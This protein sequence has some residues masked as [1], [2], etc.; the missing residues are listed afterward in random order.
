MNWKSARLR[1]LVLVMVGTILNYIARNS[2]GALAPQL[3]LDLQITTEQYSY[4]VGAFQLAYTVMQPIGGMLIDRIGLTAGFALFAVAWSVAN[5]AH[6]FARG[7]LSLAA[8]RGLLGMAEAAVIPAGMKTIGEWFPDRERSVA[9][10]WF[11]A[12][13]AFGAVIAPVMA[14]LLAKHYGWQA[15][16]VVT[17]GIGLIFAAAW[18]RWYR[19]PQDATY[20][21]AEEL[22]EIQDGQRPVPVSATTIRSIVDSS[23]YWAIAVPRFLAEPAWQTFSFWVPLYFA[24]ERGWDLTQIAMFAWVPF[25]AADAGGILGG[26]LAPWLQ[27]WKGLTLEGS[28][29]AGIWIGAVLMIAPG[30]VGLVASP[31]A[32]IGLLA[33]GGFAH[34]VISVLINTLSADVFPKSDIAKANGLVGMAG[35]TGGLLFSLAIGQFADTIGFAPLFACLGL[36]DLI[37]AIWLLALRRRLTFAK[38]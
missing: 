17:G 30:C 16:F 5:M 6:G 10:G 9:T 33:I 7:W 14:A 35:W 36:F 25:L 2:L 24:K 28:R 20:V 26:Y 12:G 21:S 19:S 11:N 23:R 22:A 3:K 1:I 32:A 31:Y 34:Q 4:I 18:Y 27:R 8:F 38:A 15:A 29:I 37:G 13:T